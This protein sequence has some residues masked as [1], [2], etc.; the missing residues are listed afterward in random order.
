MTGLE[1][2]EESVRKIRSKEKELFAKYPFPQDK[3]TLWDADIVRMHLIETNRPVVMKTKKGEN[4]AI[5]A[6]PL[7][8]H[9]QIIG[10]DPEVVVV[11]QYAGEAG[12]NGII[13]FLKIFY[14]PQPGP[15]NVFDFKAKGF[16]EMRQFCVEMQAM[17]VSVVLFL[18]K[19]WGIQKG[20]FQILWEAMGGRLITNEDKVGKRLEYLKDISGR[21]REDPISWT[22]EM[23]RQRLI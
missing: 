16:G 18:K 8:T 11:F 23:K 5:T 14:G 20:G 19:S 10:I 13:P 1:A 9:N 21:F 15:M 12:M 2:V 4:I 7:F 6:D 3:L 22:L 17:L